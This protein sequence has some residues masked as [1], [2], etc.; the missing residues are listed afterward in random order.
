MAIL[1]DVFL[2]NREDGRAEIEVLEVPTRSS[3]LDSRQERE[4]E[5]EGSSG[6]IIEGQ[7]TTSFIE[8]EG[9]NEY[10]NL[11]RVLDALNKLFLFESL[12]Q[13]QM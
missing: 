2:S 12:L 5:E 11:V 7:F 4:I 6:G 3:S 8:S 1:I 9:E 10:D 13:L